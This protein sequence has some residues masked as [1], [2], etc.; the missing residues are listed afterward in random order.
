M[1]E[2]IREQKIKHLHLRDFK[3]VR[4]DEYEIVFTT[5]EYPYWR[6]SLKTQDV[7]VADETYTRWKYHAFILQ[8]LPP[9]FCHDLVVGN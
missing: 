2:L 9:K 3:D 4:S 1:K 7:L 5:A 6:K 8:F